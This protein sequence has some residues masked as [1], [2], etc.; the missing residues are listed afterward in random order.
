V[1]VAAVPEG[2]PMVATSTLALGVGAM[3]RRN[4]LVRRLDAIETL[5]TADV[6]CFDKTGTLTHGAMSV[7]VIA[8]GDRVCHGRAES[9]IDQNGAVADLADERIKQL[10]RVGALCSEAS[11]DERDSRLV[12]TGSATE[13]ALIQTALDFGLDVQGLRRDFALL[14]LQHRTEAYRFMASVHAAQSG[15]F[16]AVKGSP[17]E[18]LARCQREALPEGGSQILTVR[19]RAAIEDLNASMARDA[20]RVLGFA[21]RSRDGGGEGETLIEDLT[22]VGLAG[23]ADPVRPGLNEL[24]GRLH[25]AG[26]QTIMLTGDQSATA[27]AVGEQI[28]L[29]GAHASNGRLRVLDSAELERMTDQERGSI[30]RKTH[31]FA[32]I[33]PGQKLEV[34]RDLQRA[35]SVVAMVGDGINDS[36]ALRAADVG[37]ALGR[38]GPA[39]A[40]EVADIFLDT[41]DLHTL[42][43]AIECGRMTAANIRKTIHYLISTNSSEVLLMLVATAAGFREALSP[44]QLLWINLISDVLP[45]IGLALEPPEADILNGKPMAVDASLV[46]SDEV[47]RLA[48]EAGLL[49]AGAL[50]ASLVGAARYGQDAPQTRTM[51]FGTLT[52]AQLLHTLNCRGTRG[53]AGPL[54][55]NP[56]LGR[57]LAGSFLAQGLAFLVPGVRRVL[58]ITPVGAADGLVMLAGSLGPYWA[59]RLLGSTRPGDGLHFSRPK[60]TSNAMPRAGDR[61]RPAS[62]KDRGAA[63]SLA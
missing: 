36:P 15:A 20:L 26:L 35:G 13:S 5:A 57:I 21:Y 10:L 27:R 63:P 53:R 24:M 59:A 38:D 55:E 51:T 6:I 23:L 28:G 30:L 17:G 44:I 18:V 11:L 43:P 42:L 33:S 3:R 25:Q 61:T 16:I 12:P 48:K 29:G 47:G 52:A 9:F 31:A 45:G 1:A 41:D 49:T 60:A 7:G 4:V 62:A 50:A 37:I 54:A 58:G 19:R 32:R 22:W 2:L 39:A 56:A 46:G 40:R 34:V 8:V 14:S